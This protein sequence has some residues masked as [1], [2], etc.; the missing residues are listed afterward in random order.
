[1]PTKEI[2]SQMGGS[3]EKFTE[4]QRNNTQIKVVKI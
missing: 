3:G 1:M 4:G 2:I